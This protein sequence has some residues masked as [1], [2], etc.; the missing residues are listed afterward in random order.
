MANAFG[1]VPQ[2]S[3]FRALQWAGLSEEAVDT[4]K[5][6]YDGCTTTI[7]NSEGSMEQVNLEA[8][9]K[10]GCPLNPIIFNL[11]MKVLLR[12]VTD[13]NLGADVMGSIIDM[14]ALVD[15]P[16]AVASNEEDLQTMLH[17]LEGAADWA[18]HIEELS[19]TYLIHHPGG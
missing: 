7:I 1:S 3:I 8:G 5:D 12:A 16:V 13:L 15:D 10:Q 14:M 18:A 19:I 9:V 2:S 4:L 11:T 6:L 17:T